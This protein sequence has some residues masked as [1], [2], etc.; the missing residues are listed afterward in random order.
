MSR[1]SRLV[2]NAY[3]IH[4]GGGKTLLNSLLQSLSR[5]KIK[6]HLI[7]DTR[8]DYKIKNDN[9]T[10]KKIKPKAIDRFIA[11]Y[12]LYK[13]T[14]ENDI[15]LC[16]G[17]MPP[18]FK[19][20]GKVVVFLQNRYLVDDKF[21]PNLPI[22]SRIR[23]E[24][25]KIWFKFCRKNADEFIVQT[26]SMCLLLKKINENSIVKI[27]PFIDD[28]DKMEPESRREISQTYEY[29]FVY[30]A[31]GESHKN[32][33]KLL[34]A[35]VYL[36]KKGIYPSL[37]ITLSQL[38]HESLCGVFTE[39][40]HKYNLNIVNV[41]NITHGQVHELYKRSRSLIFPS[42]ME[43][44]GLPLL[45][46]KR[47][48][49]VILASELDYVRDVIDPD[50]VFDPHSSISIARAVERSIS[51]TERRIFRNTEYFLN[52]VMNEV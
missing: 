48:G 52:T 41:G 17:N 1:F 15:V 37:C 16:F 38:H 14:N 23:V 39:S 43:S 28:N 26:L 12:W 44:F 3:N 31:S 11:E 9:T 25:E 40:I 35:W 42:I 4:Q 13:N 36:A 8:Y 51:R 45:E 33:E 22:K 32:H 18:I 20:K 10:L 30:I 34:E 50:E 24:I 46:A 5:N 47:E 29:D 6:N 7:L 19:L 2:V 27:I 49:M 21:R